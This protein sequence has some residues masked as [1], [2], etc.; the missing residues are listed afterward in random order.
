MA[1]A[2]VHDIKSRLE[3]GQPAFTI[4]DV[5]D[6]CTF[7]Q[8]HIMGALPIDMED[9]VNRARA[10]LHNQREIYVYGESDEQA[11][12]AVRRL[13]SIGFANVAEITGGLAAW[14]NVGGA[15][16]GTAS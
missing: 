12:D 6:R 15:V 5:R 7:N 16:E 3:W 4:I 10:S 11:A 13:K 1:N 14:K 2:D 9:L 8:G